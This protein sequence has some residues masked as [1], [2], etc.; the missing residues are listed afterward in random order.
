[1]SVLV[2]WGRF[3]DLFRLLERWKWKVENFKDSF[4]YFKF[5]KRKCDYDFC[6]RVYLFDLIMNLFVFCLEF[7]LIFSSYLNYVLIFFLNINSNF[8]YSIYG[9]I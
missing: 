7:I 2:V 6:G 8:Y 1:M 5:I 3:I 9:K 4:F